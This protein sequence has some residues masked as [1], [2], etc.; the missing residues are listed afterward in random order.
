[1]S[2]PKLGRLAQ[3]NVFIQ[4]M[5][6]YVKQH[7]FLVASN[8]K[9]VSKNVTSQHQIEM[10]IIRARE[11]ETYLGMQ[12]NKVWFLFYVMSPKVSKASS[13]VV[14]EPT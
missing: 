4:L 3:T 1:M 6:M 7:I 14:C 9:G 2:L 13:L 5:S 11:G 12:D 10:R 8:I